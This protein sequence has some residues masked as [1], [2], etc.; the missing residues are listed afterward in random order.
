[1]DTITRVYNII[2]MD[3]PKNYVWNEVQEAKS[4]FLNNNWEEEFNNINDAYDETGR[5]EAE[6]Q[7]LDSLIK[8]ASKNISDEDYFKVYYKLAEYYDLQIH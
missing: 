2:I 5:N 1:M 3:N 7:V 6:N 4:E 8:N